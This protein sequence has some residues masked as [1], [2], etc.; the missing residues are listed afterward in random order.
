VLRSI[1]ARIGLPRTV[2]NLKDS[3]RK[4]IVATAL[5]SKRSGLGQADLHFDLED[6]WPWP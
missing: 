6:H 1:V 3:S 5:A 4:K 2:F